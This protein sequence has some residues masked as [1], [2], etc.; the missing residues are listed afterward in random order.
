MGL[1][2][3]DGK[4]YRTI[5]DL[6]KAIHAITNLFSAKE[7]RLAVTEMHREGYVFNDPCKGDV[8]LILCDKSRKS[9]YY[10]GLEGI[11]S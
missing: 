2:D 1:H 10:F 8:T 9:G 5:P 6:I 3:N 7:I 11:Q 4:G